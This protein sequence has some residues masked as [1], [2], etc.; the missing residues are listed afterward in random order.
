MNSVPWLMAICFSPTVQVAVGQH[1]VDRHRNGAVEGV[2]GVGAALAAEGA[3]AGNVH[4]GARIAQQAVEVT[5]RGGDAELAGAFAAGVGGGALLAL[6]FSCSTM[7][8]VSPT[9]RGRRSSNNGW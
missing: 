3:V 8:R 7:V 5:R 1:L 9:L 6:T 2:V 4:I